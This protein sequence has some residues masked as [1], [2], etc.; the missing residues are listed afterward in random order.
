VVLN[1]AISPEER[2]I[3]DRTVA[4]L[5]SGILSFVF[6]MVG[7]IGLFGA[8]AF[9]VIRGGSNVGQHL[10]LLSQ[11]Y[12]G[13]SVTWTGALLGLVYGALTGGVMGWAIASIY[14]RLARNR[15]RQAP[16]LL[17]LALLTGPAVAQD[18]LPRDEVYEST[19]PAPAEELGWGVGEWH[20]RPEQITGYFER[21]AES[22]ARASL[23][24]IGSTHEQRPLVHLLIS[25]VENQSRLE[26]L[27][28]QH[29]ADEGPLV[30]WLG[31][32]IHGNEASGSNAALLTAYH[33]VAGKAP[34]VQELLED[35]VVIIDPMYNPDGLGRF[36]TWANMHRGQNPVGDRI[37]RSHWESWPR[38]RFN[39]YWFDLNRDWLPATQ[40]ESVARLTQ[41]H[42]WLP[43]VLGDFHELGSDSGYF[44]QPGVPQRKNPLTPEENVELTTELAKYHARALDEIGQR[45]YSR[46]VFDDFYYG[47]GSTYPDV[48]GSIGI[49]YEQPTTRGHRVDSVNGAFTFADAIRNHY[50]TS[51]STLQGAHAIRDRLIDYQSRFYTESLKRSRSGRAQAWIFAD[52]GDPARAAAL[53]EMMQVHQIEVY[54][55]GE[56]VSSNGVAFASGNAWVVPVRQRQAALVEAMFEQRTAFA[57]NTFYDVSAWTLPQAF[58]LPFA[59][60]SS[61][62][63]KLDRVAVKN[64]FAPA[65]DA[66]AYTFTDHHLAGAALAMHLLNEG[67]RV[68]RVGDQ[69]LKVTENSQVRFGDYVVPLLRGEDR[70]KVENKLAEYSKVWQVPLHAV[71]S[72]FDVSGSDLG[73]P[74]V[75]ALRAVKPLMIVGKGVGPTEAGHM[76]HLLDRRLGLP[77]P[78]LDVNGRAP[79]NLD[80]YSHLLIPDAAPKAI[81]KAWYPLIKSWVRGGGILVTQKRSAQWAEAIFSRRP[82]A[83]EASM[84]EVERI[85]GLI[86]KL[87]E[88][89][90]T[91]H[92]EVGRQPYGQFRS[93]RADRVLGGAIFSGKLDLTHPLAHGFVREQVPVFLDG[94]IKLEPSENAYSTPLVLA[95]SA[96]IAGFASGY[97]TS[98]LDGRPVLVADKVGKGLVVKFAFN[99]NFRA[100]WRGTELLY[101]NALINGSLIR[102]TALP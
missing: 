22:S 15:G 93:D 30:V 56:N 90:D 35:T 13:Y 102:E 68:Y 67:V 29:L 23:Q 45:Y 94:I 37:H 76:W 97:A 63:K 64:L 101:I 54:P 8:T 58:N 28:Q 38:G 98:E 17:L 55:L 100:F 36:A 66:T 53:V 9:L 71:T 4:K 39:H 65:S 40:P 79:I 5:R 1:E 18:I 42:H 99:P 19:V 43:H 20:A 44:F 70:E 81:P 6:A 78:M 95:S 50:A 92:E 26:E 60:V 33:L 59:Q 88:K 82:E 80:G 11:Y 86:E 3:I 12:P 41:Y 62:P 87:V 25:S 85:E 14:N 52:D 31:Y 51:I 16:L 69:K 46:E 10:G 32:S 57:D 7:G 49:L 73:S 2:I 84:K 27:R 74:T 83:A 75:Q 34:W 89:R 77:L 61:L 91:S 72:G 24:V 48:N 96:P 21:L 47:K